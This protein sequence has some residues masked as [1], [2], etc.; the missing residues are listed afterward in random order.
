MR[1]A[2]CVAVAVAA[3][4]T[5]LPAEA[6]PGATTVVS[7][8][9]GAAAGGGYNNPESVLGS[10]ERFTGEAEFGGVYAGAVTPFNAAWGFDEVVSVGAGG[11]LVVRFDQP[12]RNDPANPFGVDLIIYTNSFFFDVAYPGGTVGGVF[13][14]GPFA[15][16]VSADG[17]EFVSLGE[18]TDG[19]FPTL[20]Y[21]DLSGPYAT[22]PGSVPTDFTQPVNPALTADDFLG[23]TLG[24]I[25]ALYDGAAGGLP[26]DI[27]GSGLA[28]AWYVRIDVPAG[29]VEAPTFDALVVV[30]EPAT[31]LL[32]V[33][34]GAAALR[35]RG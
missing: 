22:T 19:R 4:G 7:Y 18:F 21:R 3:L 9:A 8:D 6:V 2:V 33:L 10:P 11:H 26:I 24:G 28:E 20:G 13:E 25:D 32:L 16:S 27:A 30:P 35:R 15:V 34:A 31:A 14:K 29:V 12:I 5:A 17:A 23:L 1:T